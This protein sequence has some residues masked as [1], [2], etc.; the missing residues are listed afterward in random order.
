[1]KMCHYLQKVPYRAIYP[2]ASVNEWRLHK[3][4]C[5]RALN[6]LQLRDPNFEPWQIWVKVDDMDNELDDEEDGEGKLFDCITQT[7]IRCV[8]CFLL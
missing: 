6:V 4:E 8:Q 7:T 3:R 1:M 2:N 5:E